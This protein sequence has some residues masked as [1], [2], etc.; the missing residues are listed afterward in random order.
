M[1]IGQASRASGVSS[2]MIR[3]YE[4]TGLIPKAARQ[5]SGY[6]DYDEADIHRL[7]FIRSARDLGFTVEQIGEL[8]ALWSDR[9]RASADVKALALG[10]VDALKQKQAEIAAMIATLENL[11]KRCHGD[12]RPDCPIIEGLA[13]NDGDLTAKARPRRF[14]KVDELRT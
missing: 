6:R 14:G 9:E 3:Y 13:E 8:L 11:A 10:H 1:N 5:D 4:Q 12:D 7:R 2:K